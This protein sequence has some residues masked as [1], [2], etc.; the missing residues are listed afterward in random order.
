MTADMIA[1]TIVV[2]LAGGG[3]A[4]SITEAPAHARLGR[5]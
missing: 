4:G 3:L 1:V 2:G 5:R